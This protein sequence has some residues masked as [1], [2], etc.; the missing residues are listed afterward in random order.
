M[1]EV[2]LEKCRHRIVYN[3][4]ITGLRG[5]QALAVRFPSVHAWMIGR[6]VLSNPFLPAI[7]KKGCDGGDGKLE[8]FKG[9]NITVMFNPRFFIDTM[10]V[11]AD[12]KI[13]LNI[14]NEEK[15]CLIEGQLDKSYLSV[16][17]PMRI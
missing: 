16:I 2:C 8:K 3:G 5:F 17:M 13:I 1:F 4:D 11:I 7:I 9:K 14:V 10:N 15:P 12:E 6:G